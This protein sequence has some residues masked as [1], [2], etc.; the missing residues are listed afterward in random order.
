[1]IFSPI[2]CFGQMSLSI[3]H[4]RAPVDMDRIP[5]TK[6]TD[7]TMYFICGGAYLVGTRNAKGDRIGGIESEAETK[8]ED[9]GVE[10]DNGESR[11]SGEAWL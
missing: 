11:R 4:G 9:C 5:E 3:Q 8:T 6:L 10:G 2:V 7:L 1:M